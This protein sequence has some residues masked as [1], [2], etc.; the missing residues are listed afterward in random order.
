MEYMKS[1]L[2]GDCSVL[3]KTKLDGSANKYDGAIC[4]PWNIKGLINK[5]NASFESIDRN[6]QSIVTAITSEMRKQGSSGY[7]NREQNEEMTVR[8]TVMRTTVCIKFDWKWL[9]FPLVLKLLATLLL[10][11]L[12]AKTTF[13]AQGIPAWKSS[14]SPLLLVGN[15]IRATVRAGGVDAIEKNTNNVVVHL[16]HMDGGWELIVDDAKKDS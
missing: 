1:M 4:H 7:S 2:F 16:A 9:G 10:S 3:S 8:G 14:V 15:Q 12:F 5:G 6:M 13:D 11:T